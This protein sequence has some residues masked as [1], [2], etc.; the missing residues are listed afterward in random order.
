MAEAN[1]ERARLS[2]FC[3]IHGAWHDGSCW[4]PLVAH[5]HAHG[6]T[7]VAPDLPYGDP[8]SG[9]AERVRPALEMLDGARDDLIV[10]GHSM[11]S[12]YSALVA[13]ELPVALLV[14]LCPRLGPFPPPPGAPAMFR[15]GF[16]FPQERPDGTSVWDPES[17]ITAIYPRLPPETGRA[18]ARRL[19][20][21]A[22]PA[23]GYPLSGQP[24]VHTVLIYS[25]DDEI[26]EPAWQRFMARELLG[27][28]PVEIPGGHFPMIED[29]AA[30]AHLLHSLARQYGRGRAGLD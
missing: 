5:L 24:G 8:T 12:A 13:A 16:P 22:P 28:E 9:Y 26:F 2:T 19:V 14:H 10:V 6:H 29:P 4:D 30:L 21:M 1:A 25:T 15:E 27:T 18:L 23:G 17:A 11:G 3:L 7:A 20:P